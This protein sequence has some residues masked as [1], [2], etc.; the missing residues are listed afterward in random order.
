VI[1]ALL[2]AA[3]FQAPAAAPYT[4]ADFAHVARLAGRW[5]GQSPGGRPVAHE[6]VLADPHTLHITRRTGA[7]AVTVSVGHVIRFANAAIT[8]LWGSYSWRAVEVTPA[9]VRFE[10]VNGPDGFSWRFIDADNVEY[11]QHWRDAQGVAQTQVTA[12]RRVR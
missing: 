5:E 10:P 4:E 12:M 8:A 6:F 3:A 1:E 11:R 7:E 2:A 9:L